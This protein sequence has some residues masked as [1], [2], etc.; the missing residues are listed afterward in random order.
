[1]SYIGI[2]YGTRRVGI[3]VSDEGGVMAFPAEVVPEEKALEHILNL[4]KEREATHI[5]LGESKDFKGAD[6][7]VMDKIRAFADELKEKSGIEVIF[8]PEFMTSA[9]AKNAGASEEMLDASAAA[10]ILQSYLDKKKAQ[11]NYSSVLQNTGKKETDEKSKT[12]SI[13]DFKKI[14]IRIGEIKSAEKVPDTDKLLRL[15]VSFGEEDRQIVSGISSYFPDPQ[16]LVGK[17]V[18]FAYNLAPRA[19]RGLESQG[20]I[21]A[22]TDNDGNFSLLHTTGVAP[23]AKIR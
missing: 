2:D 9:A 18:A 22:A 23:G 6:N 16:A 17:R 15:M 12:I 20:M 1:M 8:E 14:E 5:V 4:I 19:I 7:P 11:T 21:L 10:H 3:A 13:D